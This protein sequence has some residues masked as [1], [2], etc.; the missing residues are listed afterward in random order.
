MLWLQPLL[1]T[2][3]VSL[4]TCSILGNPSREYIAAVPEPLHLAFYLF[5]RISTVSSYR[6]LDSISKPKALVQRCAET[7]ATVLYWYK[8]SSV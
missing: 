6:Y 3:S 7:R 5:Q 4:P 1:N 8:G 2:Y